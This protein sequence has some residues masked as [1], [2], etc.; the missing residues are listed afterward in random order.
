MTA[1]TLGWLCIL[2]VLAHNAEEALYL[3]SWS[4]SAGHWNIAVGANEFRSAVGIQSL[5]L[6]GVASALAGESCRPRP[7]P[8]S[9]L[10]R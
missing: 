7:A 6:L 5:A 9:H 4:Q 8:E 10:Q 3:P 2:G 1:T